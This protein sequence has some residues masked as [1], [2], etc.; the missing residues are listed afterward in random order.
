MR[1]F[2]IGEHRFSTHEI[3]SGKALIIGS[4]EGG[5]LV[6][7]D[8]SVAPRH[9]RLSLGPP[10]ALED[11]GSGFATQLGVSRFLGQADVRITQEV[12]ALVCGKFLAQEAS[13]LGR[14]IGRAL[15]REIPPVPELP[16]V[17]KTRGSVGSYA[18]TTP[19]TAMH[20][21]SC[22]RK[23]Q[24]IGVTSNGFEWS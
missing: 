16:R 15:I 17:G 21:L 22:W 18:N 14:H 12:Y 6:V 7:S 23:K 13:K 4:D 8:A 2:V 19:T 9:A 5:D 20:K 1:L 10:L 24:K 3:P 11:L